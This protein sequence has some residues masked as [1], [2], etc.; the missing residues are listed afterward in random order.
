MPLT[1]ETKARA[2]SEIE[3][4]QAA[5]W[6]KQTGEN[7]QNEDISKASEL[8]FESMI[9]TVFAEHGELLP[10]FTTIPEHNFMQAVIATWMQNWKQIRIM[11]VQ[12]FG[13]S[14]ET[15][16]KLTEEIFATP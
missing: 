5:L 16:Q 7:A 11:H 1:N 13:L 14:E 10:D 12:L 2:M 4:Y 15:A 6:R 9:R 8:W 3:A